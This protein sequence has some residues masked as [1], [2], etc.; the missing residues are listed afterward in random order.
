VLSVGGGGGEVDA[1]EVVP[2]EVSGGGEEA[3]DGDEIA[4]F[5]Q[6]EILLW[7]SLFTPRHRG[8][9]VMSRIG[10][11]YDLAC[12]CRQRR[13]GAFAAEEGTDVGGRQ[14]FDRDDS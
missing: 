13:F 1:D 12:G 5:E 8:T 4:A 11:D 14:G 7:D 3:A 10:G 2:F 9:Q 6:E